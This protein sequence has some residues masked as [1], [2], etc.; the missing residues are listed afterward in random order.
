[1]GCTKS[2]ECNLTSV[3]CIMNTVDN[4]NCLLEEKLDDTLLLESSELVDETNFQRNNKNDD[5]I[6]V[7]NEQ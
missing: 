4:I 7:N 5:L 2:V 6:F 3:F 1:M